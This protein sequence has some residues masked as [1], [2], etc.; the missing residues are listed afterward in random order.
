MTKLEKIKVWVKDHKKGLLIGASGII[1]GT[2][3]YLVFKDHSKN[4][5]LVVVTQLNNCTTYLKK[6]DCF[7]LGVGDCYLKDIGVVGQDLI[8]E[9]G[10]SPDDEIY[11]EIIHC[12]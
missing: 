12:R 10:A 1:G 6:N 5:N 7:R 3:A 9:Y 11:M 4:D 2:V 8:E